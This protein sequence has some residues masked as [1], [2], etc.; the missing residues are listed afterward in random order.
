MEMLSWIIQVR[1]KQNQ[2]ILKT[3]LKGDLTIEEE[4][5]DMRMEAKYCSN[6]ATAKGCQ[7][8]VEAGRDKE[9][10]LPWSLQR[11]HLC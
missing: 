5:G 7:Q 1:I 9:Q 2:S 4:V 10:I 3:G 11:Y 6:G 8:P